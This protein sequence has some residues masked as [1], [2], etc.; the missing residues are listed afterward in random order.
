MCVDVPFSTCE[1][2]S[3]ARKVEEVGDVDILRLAS[4]NQR[5]VGVFAASSQLRELKDIAGIS[6]CYSM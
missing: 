3:C 2:F 1:I 6:I 4:L 5:S